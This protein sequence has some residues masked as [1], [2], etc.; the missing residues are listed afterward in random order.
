MKNIG[1]FVHTMIEN[2]SYN[3]TDLSIGMSTVIRPADNKCLFPF[4]EKKREGAPKRSTGIDRE[5]KYLVVF[6]TNHKRAVEL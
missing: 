6:L 3:K 2:I 5:T 4:A 1:H